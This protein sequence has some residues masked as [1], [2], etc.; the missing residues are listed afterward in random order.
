MKDLR[1]WFEEGASF[2]TLVCSLP[3]FILIIIGLNRWGFLFG[4]LFFTTDSLNENNE[5][6]EDLLSQTS[7][8]WGVLIVS[9]IYPAIEETT[10]RLLP[11][12][13]VFFAL[14]LVGAKH[15][16]IAL[17]TVL[18]AIAATSVVFGY[19]HGPGNIFI[20]GVSG[21][22]FA[23]VFVKWSGFGHSFSS[24]LKGWAASVLLHGS[25][26]GTFFIFTVLVPRVAPVLS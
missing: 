15:R 11:L 16:P 4:S 19:G 22:V 13:F 12:G 17:W 26:N 1:V 24:L 21:A 20:Q 6:V 25:L 8:V 7:L 23:T 10:N 14:W 2:K 5:A 3:L 18:I 9:V